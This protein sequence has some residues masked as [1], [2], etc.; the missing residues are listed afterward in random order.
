MFK[1]PRGPLRK[2][3]S[4]EDKSRNIVVCECGHER[5]IAIH[6]SCPRIGDQLHCFKCREECHAC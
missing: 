3:V 6:F 1:D 2:V 4:I 5:R